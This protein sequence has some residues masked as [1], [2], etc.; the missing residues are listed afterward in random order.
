[1]LAFAADRER[2]VL[3]VALRS[4]RLIVDGFCQDDEH[5]FLILP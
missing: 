1:L 5:A 2:K 3:T 4:Y